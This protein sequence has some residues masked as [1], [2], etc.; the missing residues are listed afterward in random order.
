VGRKAE[1]TLNTGEER[2]Y[3]LGL[4]RGQFL[5]FAVAAENP[6][7]QIQLTVVGP[8]DDAVEALSGPVCPFSLYFLPVDSGLY[9][10]RV[11]LPPS[12]T[13]PAKYTVTVSEQHEATEQ[14]KA[15]VA[16]NHAWVEA[17][18]LLVQ[19][20]PESQQQ[21]VQKYE[22]ALSLYRTADERRGQA[23]LFHVLSFRAF[24]AR[25]Y[26]TAIEQA[27]GEKEL[28]HGLA[29][30]GAEAGALEKMSQYF[31]RLGK[32]QEAL[33]S[34]NE[35]LPLLQTL[36]DRW[37]QA[38][39]LSGRGDALEAL[40]MLQDALNDKQE[41]LSIFRAGT[42]RMDYEFYALADIGHIY[43]ELG[44]S[45][46]ALDYEN[47][48]LNLAREHNNRALELSTL[49]VI[50][51]AYG[52]AGDAETARD[53][54]Q[55]AESL[56][57]G[58]RMAEV[59]V[60]VKIGTFYVKQGEYDRALP[61]FDRILPDSRT[62]HRP[63][64][65]ATALY[66]MGVAYHKQGKWQRA[67]ESLSQALSVWPHP[68]QMRR[69]IL[70][71]MA[72]VYQDSGEVPK[73]LEYYEKALTESRSAKDPQGE[74][75]ALGGMARAKR[76]LQQTTEARRDIETALGIL[77][78]VRAQIAGTE[79]RSGYF[80]TVQE[81]YEFYVDLLM[82]L[83]AE[84]PDQGFAAAALQASER[85]RA[86]GLLDMLV[87]AHADVHQGADARLLER[88]RLLQQRL[89]ARSEYQ[90][91]LLMRPHTPEQSL[92]VAHELQALTT[93]YEETEAAIRV[94]SPR[95]AALT[96][97]VPLNLEQI[98][99]QVLDPDTLLLEYALGED[100][101]YLW[102]VTSSELASYVLPKR[103]E[104]ERAVR[105]SC[106][107]LNARSTHT[108]GE[109][110][111]QAEARLAR[112]RAE[113]SIV[114][115]R[116]SDMILRPAVPLLRHKRLL[117]VSDGALQYLPFA[118]LPAPVQGGLAFPRRPL[119]QEAEIV[120]APSATTLAVMRGDLAG[121]PPA[122]KTVAVLADPVFD[123]SDPRVP[124]KAQ[125]PRGRPTAGAASAGRALPREL[126]RSW[127]DAGLPGQGWQ[128][129]RLPFSRREADAIIADAPAGDSMKAVDFQAS[130]A[131][132]TDPALAQYRIVHFATHGVFD[133]RTPALSGLVL[134]L[135]DQHGK[136]QDGFLRLWDIYNLHL[137]AD[138]VV[139]SACQ[140][141]LGKEIKGEG[142]V[143]L[144]RGFMYAGAPR[145]MA[146]LWQVDDVATAELMSRFYNGVLKKHLPPAAALRAA[147][148][149][150][151]REKRWQGDPYYWAAFEIQGEWH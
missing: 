4:V 9:R 147:Q 55:Q 115:A 101:S 15:R 77:E 70:R 49:A 121:R 140:T 136:S 95:Y 40:G 26:P 79:S 103:A 110:E 113:Y 41:A 84:H 78:S 61:L 45:E 89:R 93:Q 71:E 97:P 120:T 151:S 119:L 42:W 76:A 124:L 137:P 146:S 116:L 122:P 46:K 17:Y 67:L 8:H 112:A 32:S 6:D 7:S 12:D 53:Y 25:D 123:G 83:H 85:A 10:L 21:A 63:V 73:A 23:E 75:F 94:S 39:M 129:P 74:A 72:S 127:A 50:A 80:A 28:W 106:Q 108:K 130:R 86:R 100:R 90:V 91:R 34:L 142:L 117:I 109:S 5:R 107:L 62:W 27:R 51:G 88:E 48:A 11:Q 3:G 92:S 114:A 35:A 148:V 141:A 64:L 131:T 13:S 143:G 139:L 33:D 52:D 58:D 18:R 133:S 57:E 24:V 36:G 20:S 82:Q 60:Q 30:Y 81:N 31:E 125:R 37:G 68:D 29:E 19:N 38:M 87:E 59:W 2:V 65:E 43:E 1:G 144:T 145:V 96:Q 99:E 47:Q 98:Q 132:A 126:K 134:S 102:A 149:S 14:D 44:D 111:T 105:R 54:Y 104:I 22:Q 128:I 138:L 66:W 56:A 69:K 135:V 150:V 118:A 16:A